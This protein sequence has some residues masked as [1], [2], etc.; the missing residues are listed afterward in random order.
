MRISGPGERRR[1][2]EFGEEKGVTFGLS[3]YIYFFNTKASFF[4]SRALSIYARVGKGASVQVT[5]PVSL[6]FFFCAALVP[7]AL[8]SFYYY[9][10]FSLFFIGHLRG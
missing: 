2:A 10:F 3:L 8:F 5:P 4:F 6:L 7:R 9:Y 1:D